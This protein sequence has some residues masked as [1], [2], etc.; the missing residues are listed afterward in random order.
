MKA[1]ENN[2]K[3]S[4]IKNHRIIS[5]KRKS[6]TKHRNSNLASKK[7]KEIFQMIRQ[8]KNNQF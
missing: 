4:R 6:K 7:K 1:Q 2:T 8:R 3:T 5:L